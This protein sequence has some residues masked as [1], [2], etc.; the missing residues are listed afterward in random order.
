[1]FLLWTQHW[2]F[3]FDKRRN[4]MTSWATAR[5]SRKILLRGVRFYPN[6][7]LSFSS[8]CVIVNKWQI[9]VVLLWLQMM[10]QSGYMPTVLQQLCSLPFPYFSN[11][12]LSCLLFPTLLACCSGNH[13]NR[14]ILE[15]EVSYQVGLISLPASLQLSNQADSLK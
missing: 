4:F 8:S 13:Q 11:P 14:A 7:N 9:S 10:I 5:L 2:S 15:Q 3:W 12:A 6:V 1:M